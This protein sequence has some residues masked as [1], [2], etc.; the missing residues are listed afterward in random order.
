MD[1]LDMEGMCFPAFLSLP[2]S[3]DSTR[4]ESGNRII[5][6]FTDDVISVASSTG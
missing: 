6:G 3:L 4:G 1:S 5:M 2:H